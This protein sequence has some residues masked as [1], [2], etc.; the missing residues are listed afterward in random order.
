MVSRMPRATFMRLPLNH[1]DV[2]L[3]DGFDTVVNAEA[4]FF[5][6]QFLFSG[7]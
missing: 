1:F 5:A 4:D 7:R 3:G 6:N 2:C